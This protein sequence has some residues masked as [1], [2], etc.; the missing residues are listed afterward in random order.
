MDPNQEIFMDERL[1]AILDEI[2]DMKIELSDE[3]EKALSEISKL[4][5][6]IKEHDL[7]KDF[8][9]AA[10]QGVEDYLNSFIDTS[11]IVD[12]LKN[13]SS[14]RNRNG[15]TV[16]AR[17]PEAPGRTLKEAKTSP[18]SAD[19][20]RDNSDMSDK[21]R[22]RLAYYE[23]AYKQRL[24]TVSDKFDN[25]AGLDKIGG[26]S[27][28][29]NELALAGIES[30]QFGPKVDLYTPDEYKAMYVAAGSPDSPSNFIRNVNFDKFYSEKYT[31]FGFDNKTQFEAWCKDNKFSIHETPDGMYL[32]PRDVHA[33]ESHSGEV[34]KL[35]GYLTGKNTKEELEMFER[36]V[37]I[38]KVKHEV[39]TRAAR[40]GMAIGMGSV[41]I[42]IQQ[43]AS[44]VVT[45][46]YFVFSDKEK[47]D[48]SFGNKM[49]LLVKNCAL[50]MKEQVKPTL[51]K[52][53]H[54]AIGNIGTEILH[55]LN[56]FVLKTAKNIIKVI[57]AMIGSIV[58]ALK[59]IFGK[60]HS[61]EEKIF[62]ALKILSGGLVAA[63]GFS[64]NE[65]ITDLITG[66]G[67]PPLVAIAPILG[68]VLS[69]LAACVL[70]ALVLMLF[71]SFKDNLDAKNAENK[72]AI[73]G[74]RVSGYRLALAATEQAKTSAMVAKTSQLVVASVSD[75]SSRSEDID[76]TLSS[77]KDKRRKLHERLMITED[78]IE[79]SEKTIAEARN[80][81]DS[82]NS[83]LGHDE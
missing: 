23:E 51:K 77:V 62:E 2:E 66:T 45:E 76:Q 70:S 32:V 72:M 35:Q 68:D 12:D 74:L 78:A 4:K 5:G 34:S 69:G 14:I 82:I 9:K 18:Y 21:G 81:L 50:K 65:F 10:Q 48:E 7:L 52:L 8:G 67:I 54:G 37:R 79:R 1:D 71:D 11:E 6:S 33:A 25:L 31:E 75:M 16:R 58:R 57:R 20:K 38:S 22:R 55:A 60:G 19:A 40:T 15:S 63:L 17:Q 80:I 47:K 3:E 73:L 46:T 59:V 30:F 41:K 53:A 27:L 26:K 36:E 13:P 29:N 43:I 28:T 56:D 61:W 42:L 83:H 49:K 24:K 64:M 39:S 44:I